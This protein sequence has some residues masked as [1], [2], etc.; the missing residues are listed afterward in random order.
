MHD[1]R[2]D[3]AVLNSI[4][5]LVR[6]QT[7][8]L[9]C[10]FDQQEMLKLRQFVGPAAL[11]QQRIWGAMDSFEVAKVA[12]AV[13]SALLVI[14]G[15]NTVL[16]II[17]ESRTPEKPGYTLPAPAQ[18][19]SPVKPGGSEG[20]PAQPTFNAPA[21]VKAS[22]DGNVQSGAKTFKK[23]QACHDGTKGGP[24]KVGPNLW[25][26]VGRPKASHEGFNYS[27]AM[28]AKGGNWTPEDL[29]QFVHSPKTFVPGTKMLFP[30]IS[31][32][33]ELADL[34]A[35]LNTLK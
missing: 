5:G 23:C 21:V 25:G 22:A 26:V 15:F 6:E 16:E 35:Y 14:V 28:K 31:D 29:A 17:E 3:L 30:G 10:F 32:P 1:G 13:L 11:A 4:N 18:Q 27:D 7:S 20:L 2:A 8:L 12:G 9:R 24:N 34:L 33:S 19:A